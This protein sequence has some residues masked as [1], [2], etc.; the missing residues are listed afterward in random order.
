MKAELLKRIDIMCLVRNAAKAA[1]HQLHRQL[2][3]LPQRQAPKD[4]PIG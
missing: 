3:P 4:T 1:E 2:Q